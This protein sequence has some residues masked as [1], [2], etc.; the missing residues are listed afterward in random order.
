[1]RVTANGIPVALSAM[2]GGSIATVGLIQWEHV[3]FLTWQI[4]ADLIFPAT[5][6]STAAAAK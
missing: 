3:A 5:S 2:F 4:Y 6:T 1:M